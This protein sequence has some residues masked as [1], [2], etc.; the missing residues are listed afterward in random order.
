MVIFSKMYK[1]KKTTK[2][3][4]KD[5]YF[6]V[7]YVTLKLGIGGVSSQKEF[8]QQNSSRHDQAKDHIFSLFLYYI[9]ALVPALCAGPSPH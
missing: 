8:P 1:W 2:M 5:A 6:V 4:F 3:N 7:E 9:L